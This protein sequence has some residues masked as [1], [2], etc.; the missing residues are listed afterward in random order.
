MNWKDGLPEGLLTKMQKMDT[1][2]SVLKNRLDSVELELAAYKKS[3]ENLQ[4]IITAIQTGVPHNERKKY[5]PAR[6]IIL[7]KKKT[8][9]DMILENELE[10]KSKKRERVK[11]EDLVRAEDALAQTF[12]RH[13]MEYEPTPAELDANKFWNLKKLYNWVVVITNSD[14]V[15]KQYFKRDRLKSAMNKAGIDLQ[16]RTYEYNVFDERIW[17]KKYLNIKLRHEDED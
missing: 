4:N 10:M 12:K 6:F 13:F 1:S 14:P 3:H 11:P 17:T 7:P 9:T 2:I 15:F 5:N 8:R 16:M